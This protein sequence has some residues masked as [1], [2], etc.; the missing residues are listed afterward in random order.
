MGGGNLTLTPPPR[1]VSTAAFCQGARA[2]C[3]FFC[4]DMVSGGTWHSGCTGTHPAAAAARQLSFRLGLPCGQHLVLPGPR[5]QH[6]GGGGV[7]HPSQTGDFSPAWGTQALSP[8]Q[9]CVLGSAPWP[10]KEAALTLKV[11]AAHPASGWGLA[12]ECWVP[13]R[14]LW[15]AFQPRC[16]TPSEVSLRF[17]RISAC[18]FALG[19]SPSRFLPRPVG[20]DRK[21]HPRPGTGPAWQC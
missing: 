17:L 14:W 2:K 16:L 8:G 13:F 19:E 7:G 1:L 11:C 20:S 9:A 18:G 21:P 4:G 15:P 3:H 5:P 12:S 10:D 6:S